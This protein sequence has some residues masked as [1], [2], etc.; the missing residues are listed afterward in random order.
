MATSLTSCPS[1]S[2]TSC[3]CGWSRRWCLRCWRT[4]SW[5]S[6]TTAMGSGRSFGSPL[7]WCSR[8]WPWPWRR[9]ASEPSACPSTSP[10]F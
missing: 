5:A 4:R 1:P 10:T 6:T 8:T 2:P 9:W 3:W 7:S